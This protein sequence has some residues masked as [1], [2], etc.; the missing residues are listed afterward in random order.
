M[1]TKKEIKKLKFRVFS[2]E[3]IRQVS[4]CTVEVPDTYNEDGLPIKNG[5]MDLRMGVIDPGR[6]SCT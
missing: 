4:V 3:R 6:R 1:I 5:L 2:P